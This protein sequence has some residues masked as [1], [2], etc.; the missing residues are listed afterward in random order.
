MTSGCQLYPLK[1]VKSI[2]YGKITPV[3]RKSC[4]NLLRPYF[5]F[6][7][8]LQKR[9]LDFYCNDYEQTCNWVCGLSIKLKTCN[10]K[11]AG[12]TK[13]KMRWR[14]MFMILRENFTSKLK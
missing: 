14:K 5:C 13:G 10:P 9:T 8:H 6:S 3:M 2:F 11:I 1:D 12:Y 4:N 7:L